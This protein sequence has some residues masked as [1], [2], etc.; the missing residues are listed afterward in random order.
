MKSKHFELAEAAEAD[1][2]G[3]WHYI[4]SR[5][6]NMGTADRVVEK[7]TDGFEFLGNNPLAGH[8]L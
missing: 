7:I 2:I 5:S 8:L 1:L 4:R 6:G 3:I